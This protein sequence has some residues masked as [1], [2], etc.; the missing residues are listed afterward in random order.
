MRADLLDLAG[1]EDEDGR[2]RSFDREFRELLS[3]WFDVGFLELRRITW[4]ASA[5][6]LEKLVAYEAVHEIRSWADLKDRLDSDRR[7]YAFFH[8]N[9]PNEPLIFVEVALT[10]GM[11]D[12]IDTLLDEHGPAADPTHADAA[13]FYSISNAQKGLAGVSFGDFLIKQVVAALARDFPGIKTF[14]TL[15]P[16]PDFRDWLAAGFE[17]GDLKL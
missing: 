3:S 16:I 8:P 5:A 10:Q 15:S 2:Y 6:L 14:A 9:M 4:E 1:V 12:R 13:V 11:A 7:C 17:T